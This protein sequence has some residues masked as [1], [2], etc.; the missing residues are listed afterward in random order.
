[1]RHE[2]QYLTSAETLGVLVFPPYPRK[3]HG[4]LV[5]DKAVP[6]HRLLASA[7][8]ASFTILTKHY[9][10]LLMPVQVLKLSLGTPLCT[11]RTPGTHGPLSPEFNEKR[12]QICTG[13]RSRPCSRLLCSQA[14]SRP[15]AATA[16]KQPTKAQ[17]QHRWILQQEKKSTKPDIKAS[18]PT[19][20]FGG[21]DFNF[22][23]WRSRRSPS[24][25]RPATS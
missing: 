13:K 8:H 7:H 2:R 12:S 11:D 15:A 4:Y 22:L 24:R 19:G 21:T 25:R 14:L 1:M 3:R 18:L 6:E 5:V 17:R 10:E 9:L 16:R 23:L 20:G